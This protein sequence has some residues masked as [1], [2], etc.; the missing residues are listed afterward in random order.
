MHKPEIFK[1]LHPAAILLLGLTIAPVHVKIRWLVL[2]SI[3]RIFCRQLVHCL[4]QAVVSSH[5]D[6]AFMVCLNLSPLNLPLLR[7]LK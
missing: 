1:N 5:L 3:N 2:L 7:F 6:Q 4:M